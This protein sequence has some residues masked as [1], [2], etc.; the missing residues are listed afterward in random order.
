[1]KYHEEFPKPSSVSVYYGVKLVENFFSEKYAVRVYE[2]S[3]DGNTVL[4]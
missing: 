4:K 2:D 1:M 3:E